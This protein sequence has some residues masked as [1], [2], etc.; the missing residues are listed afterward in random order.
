[1]KVIFCGSFFSH[2]RHEEIICRSKGAVSNANNLLQ[3]NIIYGLSNFHDNLCCIALPNIGSYPKTYKDKFFKGNDTFLEY[4]ERII[5]STDLPFLNYR[6]IKHLFRMFSLIKQLSSSLSREHYTLI[7][8]YDC[9]ISFLMCTPLLKILGYKFNTCLIIPDLPTMTGDVDSIL[10]KF[11]K[12]TLSILLKNS[13]RFIDTFS[14]ISSGMIDKLKLDAN[15]TIVIEGI[16]NGRRDYLF[17]K[18]SSCTL[19]N[20][21]IFY[22]GAIDERNGIV[23]L[24][25][26]FK[27]INDPNYTLT[28]VG[29]GPL[30]DWL[31]LQSECDIRI[32]YLGQIKHSSVLELQRKSDLLI[33]PR[34]PNQSFTSYSFPSK[35][36]EYLASGI[37]VLMF[38]LDGVPDEYFKYVTLCHSNTVDALEKSIC[39]ILEC[40]YETAIS[41]A[42]TAKEFI[43]K[44]KNPYVQCKKL[45]ELNR[46][47]Y[48]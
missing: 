2:E 17:E 46:K 34:I 20:K 11:L 41:K 36:M 26:A 28:I 23:L 15:K 10:I 1:M 3:H 5:Q 29:E 18:D 6:I 4:G 12:N 39:S 33:N 35:T 24:V 47:F 16:Y 9:D 31:V 14:V 44:C 21:N 42:K 38:K 40:D 27:R 32:N 43:L 45:Y 48:V 22:S 8:F 37:P 7:Y 25:N 13:L 30:A 19:K